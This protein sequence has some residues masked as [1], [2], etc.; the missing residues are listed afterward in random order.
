MTEISRRITPLRAALTVLVLATATI[1]GAWVFESFGY[2]PCELCLQ[3]RWAYYVGVPVAALAV[4]LAW[5]GSN[6][7]ARL[8]LALLAVVFFG[9]AV[10]GAYHAG[11]EWGFWP[12]PTGCTG[13]AGAPAA[14]MD[15]FMSHLQ[16]VKVVR[17]DQVA[18]RI[19]GLS[20]AG[21]NAVISTFMTVVALA[22]ARR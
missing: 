19:L 8:G 13:S 2:L 11:V 5:R 1:A 6:G 21:W 12:G 20:L 16:T 14:S 17:C 7:G 22:G 18:I 3:Q 10:F 9:S 15:A 4:A